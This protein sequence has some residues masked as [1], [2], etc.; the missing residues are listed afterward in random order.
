MVSGRTKLVLAL[1]VAI[2][3]IAFIDRQLPFVLAESIRH[4]LS[5]T[6]TE[7]GLIGGLAFALFYA[8]AVLP[9][10]AL[11]DRWS[12][13]W[14]LVTCVS[15]WSLT[16][17]LGALSTGFWQLAATRVGV[18]VGE[19]AATPASHVM[20]AQFWP[21]ERRAFAIG[22]FATGVPI[23]I[24]LG[25]GLGGWIN[26]LASWR[27][28][29]VLI[30]V[31]GLIVAAAFAVVAPNRQ[32]T[33]APVGQVGLLAGARQLLAMR[34]Y[35]F[36]AA[37]MTMFGIG[38]YAV[39]AFS[40]PFLI[41]VQ[42]MNSTQAGMT[43][44]LINGTAGVVGALSG[45]YFADRLSRLDQRYPLYMVAAGLALCAPLL[46]ASWL[47]TSAAMSLLLL[48]LP[49]FFG[50]LYAAT[51]FSA[52]QSLAPNNARAAASA[53]PLLGQSLIG[54][55]LGPLLVGAISD[56]LAPMV[57]AQS[58]RY[59]LCVVTLGYLASAGLLLAATIHLPRDLAHI[60]RR[61]AA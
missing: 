36:L 11:A 44:G 6:D 23:G 12:A 20:I 43:L 9:L 26:D 56:Y 55:S 34:S 2:N 52:A 3:V 29:L 30:G 45:G 48:T 47:A 14:V 42:G 61:N 17:A 40:A 8:G 13:K 28:A 18:A 25:L 35:A 16:T 33:A 58:L 5:L 41:R 59:A 46:I 24:M 31:P 38:G 60:A 15:L 54:A 1:L 32:T 39:F 19:A 57:G 37:G 4:D 27:V 53:I 21:P 51:C 49:T 22:I 10:A 50:A 7:I